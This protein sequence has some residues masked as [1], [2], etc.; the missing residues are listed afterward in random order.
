MSYSTSFPL[1]VEVILFI[2]INNEDHCHDYLSKRIIS[3]KLEV[4]VPTVSKVISKLIHSGLL[5]S[6]E[7]VKGG[8]A[9]VK[10]ISATTLFEVFDAIEK[11]NPLF[12]IPNNLKDGPDFV[13]KMFAKGTDILT[14]AES[15][16]LNYLKG[17]TLSDLM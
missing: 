12:K 15:S 4:P 1:A 10:P 2:H 8:I 14:N 11:G 9:L 17:Y 6:K 3:E 16:M 5:E 13:G 7:G